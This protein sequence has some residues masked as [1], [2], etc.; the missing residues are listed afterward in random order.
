[1]SQTPVPSRLVGL[2]RFRGPQIVKPPLRAGAARFPLL[3]AIAAEF[4][5]LAG[6]IGAQEPP[7]AWDAPWYRWFGVWAA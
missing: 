2:D 5:A 7:W 1:M 6:Q 3:A 4:G